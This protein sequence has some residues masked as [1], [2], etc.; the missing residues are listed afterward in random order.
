MSDELRH[1]VDLVIFMDEGRPYDFGKL[2]LEGIEPHAGAG[3]AL[4]NSWKALE[5][6]RYNPLELH[7]WLLANH[8]DWKVSSDSMRMVI[9]PNPLRSM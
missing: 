2:Y 3:K 9:D 5:G 6:K 1:T 8:A 7:R 4:L